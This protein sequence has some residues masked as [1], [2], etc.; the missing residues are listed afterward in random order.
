MIITEISYSLCV[1]NF[2]NS[3]N[4]NIKVIF[5]NPVIR[6]SRSPTAE[7]TLGLGQNANR[8]KPG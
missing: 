7:L 5:V 4:E 2:N 8:P 1:I 3:F 6:L